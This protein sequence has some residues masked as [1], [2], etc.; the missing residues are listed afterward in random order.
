[1]VFAL[2]FPGQGAQ[3]R[4]MGDDLFWR[5]PGLTRFA[6]GVLGYD[7]AALCRDDPDGVLART[8]YTQPALFVVNAL[9]TF[10][11]EHD[12]Q[13]RADYYLGHSLG[14]YNALLAAGA[15]DFET[16]LRLVAKRAELMDAASGGGMTAVMDVPEPRLREIFAEHD[17]SGV[18]IAGYN[19][20]Q[21]LV[22]AATDE[23]LRAAHAALKE[24]R[25]RFAPL[26]VSAPFHSRYMAPVRAEFEEFLRGFTFDTPHTPVIANTTGRPHR[27]D[28]LVAA[29]GEQLVSPV[30]WTDSVRHLLSADPDLEHEEIGGRAVQRMVTRIRQATPVATTE[31]RE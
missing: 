7:L 21:Q 16:G 2:L 10:E 3:F 24:H 1:M 13:R 28:G 17:V 27:P 18:D 11:R 15:F 8:R 20:D 22:I 26:K 19:T 31:S 30:R 25:V 4:G 14:E 29:L 6:A 12:E 5:Y 23:V 9:H